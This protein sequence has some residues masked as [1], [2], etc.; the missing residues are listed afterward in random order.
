MTFKELQDALDDRISAANITG[1]WSEDAKKQWLNDAGQ[2]VCDYRPWEFLRVAKTITTREDREYY[3]Y[4]EEFKYNSIYNIVIEDEEYYGA[5]GRIRKM[6]DSF[7]KEKQEETGL[8]IFTN[9]NQWYF[10]YP[11]PENDKTM[12]IYGIRKWEEL[13]NDSD[14]PISPSELDEAIIRVALASCLRKSKR[15]DEANIE[16]A[17]VFSPES[18]VLLNAWIQEQGEAPRGYVGRIKTT[19]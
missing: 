1:F 7:Q 6:W 3:D 18:G 14:E 2:R 9:H 4:P 10:L 16:T 5:G 15:Y 11:V 13:E 17:E 8:K 19:R 12:Q